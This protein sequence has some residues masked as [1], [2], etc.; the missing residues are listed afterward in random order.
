MSENTP[1]VSVCMPASRESRWFAD[2]VRSVL[3]QSFTDFEIVVTDDSG[4][5]LAEAVGR[6]GDAR[7]RYVPNLTRLG[8]AGNHCR[9]IDEA[10]GRY[11]TFLHDDDAWEPEYLAASASILDLYP[12]A[13]L[14]LAGA[15]E[16]DANGAAIG[17]RPANMP[18]GLVAR[19]LVRMLDPA[20]MM[21]LPS[22]TM[23]RRTALEANTRP[24]PDV[25]AADLTMYVDIVQ[26]GWQIYHLDTPL[27]RYRV[28]AGQIGADALAHRHALVS[29]WKAYTFADAEAEALRRH[30]VARA[31]IGRAATLLRRREPARARQDLDGAHDI[32]P[33]TARGRRLALRAVSRLPAA[34]VPVTTAIWARLG[35]GHRHQGV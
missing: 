10:R 13:G 31:L 11:I 15:T 19:P 22:L 21:L 25:I 1:V 14:V 32:S 34:F 7:I 18:P 27:V 23:V 24:W 26:A 9:A 16:V 2:A 5:S 6:F 8:F 33:D 35:R 30:A 20:F 17:P 28:H 3:A 12:E 4:G 29:V